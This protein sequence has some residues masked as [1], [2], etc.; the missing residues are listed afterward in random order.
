MW[1]L[2]YHTM[3]LPTGHLPPK[4]WFFLIWYL[5]K[6]QVLHLWHQYLGHIDRHFVTEMHYFAT[7]IPCIAIPNDLDSCP[8]CLSSKIHH[9]PRG[10]LNTCHATWCYQGISI[11]FVFFVQLS[12]DPNH[13][14]QLQGLNGETC[15]CLIALLRDEFSG[16]ISADE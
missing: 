8:I 11:D 12:S 10:K 16:P 14:H 7:G 15:Y 4:Q 2:N 13:L 3:Y 5:T 1:S 9:A 6:Q